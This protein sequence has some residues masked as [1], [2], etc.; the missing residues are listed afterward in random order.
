MLSLF[1][2]SALHGVLSHHQGKL[3]FAH[4]PDSHSAN[5]IS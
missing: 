4:D 3:L 5:G 1:L 2:L